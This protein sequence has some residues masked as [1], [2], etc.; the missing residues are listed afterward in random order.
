MPLTLAPARDI[1]PKRVLTHE[2]TLMLQYSIF[3]RLHLD[4][5]DRH[6]AM[7]VD[8]RPW[9]ISR[10]SFHA[11]DLTSAA[12]ATFLGPSLGG[13]PLGSRAPLVKVDTN[14]NSS[15]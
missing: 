8:L 10:V 3:Q 13:K 15:S 11:F 7:S 2:C 1:A 14:C 9:S 12:P 6:L 4:H 5:S